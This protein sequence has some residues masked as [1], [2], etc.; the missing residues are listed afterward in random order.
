MDVH[1]LRYATYVENALQQAPRQISPS[2]VRYGC[3]NSSNR[4]F[5]IEL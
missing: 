1:T 3:P 5:T 2:S 4:G